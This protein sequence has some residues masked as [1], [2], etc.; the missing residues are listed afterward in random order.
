MS[1]WQPS[2][3]TPA[4][5][6]QKLGRVARQQPFPPSLFQVDHSERLK[7]RL[8]KLNESYS[9]VAFS[10]AKE[11][12]RL[13]IRTVSDAF[14]KL[15]ELV[16]NLKAHAIDELKNSENIKELLS[17][18]EEHVDP[19]CQDLQEGR[20]NLF[21]QIDSNAE[22]CAKRGIKAFS[23]AD[24][25][26]IFQDIEELLLK[27]DE[28]REEPTY[29]VVEGIKLLWSDSVVEKEVA[30]LTR[31]ICRLSVPDH[32]QSLQKQSF[33]QEV[34]LGQQG[35]NKGGVLGKRRGFLSEFDEMFESFPRK[36]R[37]TG[38]SRAPEKE[39][40]PETHTFMTEQGDKYTGHM[41]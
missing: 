40:T 16:L 8:V 15:S 18:V 13:C 29:K 25:R 11:V 6:R 22:A 5:K 32:K 27:C 35:E 31:R 23:A 7:T 24:E 38:D 4:H 19:L 9:A 41:N 33:S 34:D 39:A 36:S 2:F 1:V 28:I 26:E 20:A 30:D 10:T 12:R 17:F 3:A 14:D 21:A 37:D